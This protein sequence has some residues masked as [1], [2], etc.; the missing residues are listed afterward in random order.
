MVDLLEDDPN[1]IL[2]AITRQE[3]TIAR[4]IRSGITTEDKVESACVALD[5]ELD[6]HVRFQEL[7]S[8]AVATGL[9]TVSEGQTIYNAL[10]S[11]PQ[12]FNDQPVHVKLVLT[13]FFKELL[14]RQIQ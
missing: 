12:T 6:E 13:T 8:L 5:M 4:R 14:D 1:R 2:S 11:I 10:G 7:K 9:I 3:S